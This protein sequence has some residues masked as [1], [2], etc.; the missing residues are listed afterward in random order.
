MAVQCLAGARDPRPTCKLEECGI[1]VYV[2]DRTGR[3]FDYCSRTHAEEDGAIVTPAAEE[4]QREG[5]DGDRPSCKLASCD[6]PVYVDE[7]TG[8]VFDYYSQTHAAEDGATRP[9]KAQPE[10][11]LREKRKASNARRRCNGTKPRSGYP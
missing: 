1:P 10:P 5:G 8:R 6:R 2:D 11:A 7:R 3:V 4:A 9:A